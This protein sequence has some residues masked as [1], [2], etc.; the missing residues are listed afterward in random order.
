MKY[1]FK[2]S[3]V[4]L[5]TPFKN[6]KVDFDSLKKLINYQL[7]NGTDAILVL[8]TTGEPS[9]MT[10]EE[11]HTII[12]FAKNEIGSK[13]KLIVGTGGNNTQKVIEDSLYAKEHGADALLVVTPYYN[14]CTQNGLV[15]HYKMVAEAVKMPIIAYNVPG[16]T[17]VNILPETAVKLAEIPEICGIKEASGNINQIISISKALKEKMAVYSGDDSLN[18]TFMT[19]G[20]LGCISVTAN[21]LPKEVKEVVDLCFNNNYALACEKHEKLLEVNKNLFIEVN[22][23]PVKYAA[24]VMNLCGGEIR[25]PLTELEDKNKEVVKESLKNYGVKF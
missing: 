13:A 9:T 16:R 21:V 3:C 18:Y 25:M 2:G 7:D 5:I 19:L 10:V 15:K 22:P 4:A 1:V 17:G 11:K 23:I 12:D 14:K 20:S 6:D 24:E 8:G